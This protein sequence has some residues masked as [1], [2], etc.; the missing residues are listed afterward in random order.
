MKVKVGE[1]T[2]DSRD[3]PILIEYTEEEIEII[4]SF[5]KGNNA[6]YSYPA[7]ADPQKIEAWVTRRLNE[8]DTESDTP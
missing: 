6:I 7:D 4:H 5:D 1:Q 3:Y 8:E 2:V